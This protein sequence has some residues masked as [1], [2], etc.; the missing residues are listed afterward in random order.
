MTHR[1]ANNYPSECNNGET[2]FVLIRG[3]KNKG[4]LRSPFPLLDT[5][6]IFPV[7]FLL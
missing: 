1:E 4:E 2:L 6:A 7:T 5:M 3:R